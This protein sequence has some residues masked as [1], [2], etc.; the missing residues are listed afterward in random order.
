MFDSPGKAGRFEEAS[1]RAL[2][3]VLDES[4][5]TSVTV[6]DDDINLGDFFGGR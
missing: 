1:S 3:A 2:V 6:L 4:C 5:S